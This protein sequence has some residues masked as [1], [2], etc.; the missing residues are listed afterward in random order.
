M[1]S[2]VTAARG[3]CRGSS[4]EPV[5]AVGPGLSTQTAG[6]RVWWGRSKPRKV[7]RG[8]A[9]RWVRGPRRPCGRE[10]VRSVSTHL[11][12]QFLFWDDLGQRWD[13]WFFCV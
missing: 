5:R 7:G 1:L 6:G 12:W 13:G 11:Q 2:A 3:R 10:S 9:L 8:H 4:E